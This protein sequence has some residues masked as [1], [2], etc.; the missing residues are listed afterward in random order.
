[1]PKYRF[2]VVKSD[3]DVVGLPIIVEC[4]DDDEALH[5]AQEYTAQNTI[6]IWESERWVGQIGP[7]RTT[8]LTP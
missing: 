3:G 8:K 5:R 2:Y 1:M 7:D 6:E 4:K